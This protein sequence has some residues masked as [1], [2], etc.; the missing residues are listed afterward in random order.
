[1]HLSVSAHKAHA[2]TQTVSESIET[3][4]AWSHSATSTDDAA[5]CAECARVIPS[6]RCM[7]AKLGAEHAAQLA[8][9]FSHKRNYGRCTEDVTR[10]GSA[11]QCKRLEPTSV[12][13]L[14]LDDN[15]FCRI[16][17]WSCTHDACCLTMQNSNLRFDNAH[18]WS[19]AMYVR[20]RGFL[21]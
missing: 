5:R 16:C 19:I 2:C 1:M 18:W 21:H 7:H 11:M 3:C 17:F 20:C 6:V 8:C 10:Q 14:T 15:L 9:K 4:I 12:S 13:V